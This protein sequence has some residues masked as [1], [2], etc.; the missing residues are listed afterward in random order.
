MNHTE[1][2]K[3]L[4]A[5]FAGNKCISPASVYDG[6]SARVAESVGYEI[7]MLAGSVAANTTLAAPDLIVLTLTE[8]ADQ[9]RRIMRASKLSLIVD[10]D[11]GYGNALNVMRTVEE[12]EH[13]GVS[14]MSIEDTALP[15][16]F[17]QTEGTDELISLDEM[18]GKLKAAVA[19]RRDPSTV[20]LGRT[21]A[22]KV[23]GT[24]GT[25]KRA[26]AFAA[27]GVDA[28][29]VV[30]VESVDQVRA[31]HEAAKLPIMVGGA[32]AS[33]RHEDVA[34]AGGRVMLQGH[35]P[36]AAAVKAVREVYTHLFNGGA[37]ADL[38]DRIAAQSEIDK[39]VRA[40]DYKAWQK[41]YLGVKSKG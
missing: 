7:G 11:H 1:Q 23:E 41:D 35:Q 26:K 37:P 32:P 4:R 36:V 30:G 8:F 17:G 5:V 9:V 39:L 14:G 21:A 3:R 38:K 15:T 18:V 6:L 33:V 10:A 20:I 29:F 27:C 16:R 31:V 2:R 19:A 24:E 12:L 22:L 25:V 40:A 13:A 28:I 34:A